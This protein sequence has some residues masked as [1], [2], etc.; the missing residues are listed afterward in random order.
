LSINVA[1][2]L[3]AFLPVLFSIFMTGNFRLQ[4]ITIVQFLWINLIMDTLGATAFGKEPHLDGYMK[5]KPKARDAKIVDKVVFSEV[6]VSGLTITTMSIIFLFVPG[7]TAALGVEHHSITHTT[8]FFTFFVF[9]AVVNAFTIR[10]KGCWA[11]FGDD[12]GNPAF[13]RIY[14]GIALI[15]VA[16]VTIL[17]DFSVFS[18]AFNVVTLSM[19]Q[20][21][22]MA[23]AALLIVP[24]K[25]FAKYITTGG[26]A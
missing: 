14:L 18:K 12:G 15:Q 13:G 11:V 20:V 5:E 26:K 3:C 7:I 17:S 8:M 4:P 6:L 1:A 24:V 9:A 22:L 21:V 25:V 23:A 2:V 16:F 19:T 10:K